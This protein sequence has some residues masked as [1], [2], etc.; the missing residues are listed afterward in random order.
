M[1]LIYRKPDTT[2]KVFYEIRKAQPKK[3]FIAADGPEEGEEKICEQT[4][5]VVKII[6]WDCDTRRLYHECYLDVKT[7]VSS[8]IDW[9]FEN[10]EYNSSS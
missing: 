3:L 8:A 6:D 10:A 2:K 5:E 1:F 9:F 4:R 7:S